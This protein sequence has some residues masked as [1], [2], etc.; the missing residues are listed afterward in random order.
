MKYLKL[1]SVLIILTIAMVAIN[2]THDKQGFEQAILKKNWSNVHKILNT[3]LLCSKM[4]NRSELRIIKA[5]A[6]LA[7]NKNNKSL[8]YFFSASSKK[9][10]ER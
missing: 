5:H 1:F 10:L 6:C 8:I 2:A 4:K 9:C 3:K 7:L